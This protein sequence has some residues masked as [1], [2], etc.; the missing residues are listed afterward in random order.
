M[1]RVFFD[2]DGTLIDSRRRLYEL[3]KSMVPESNFS[4]DEYWLLKRS[5]FSHSYILGKEYKYHHDQIKQFTLDWMHLIEDEKWIKYDTDYEGVTEHLDFLTKKKN[6]LYL[7][8]NRQKKDIVLKQVEQ[9][10][11]THFFEEILVTEQTTTKYNIIKPYVL[12]KNECY[13]VAD[14]G[15]DI[16]EGKQLGIH[17]IAVT[18]G[19]L[20]KETLEQY[21]PDVII[22]DVTK[23]II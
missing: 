6:K 12:N 8:T 10:K 4:F 1:K 16:E 21:K 5:G 18:S 2:F 19:F 23:L 13:L 14:T 20:N 9:L 7:T 3:F 11:W 22:D 17:T 15:K